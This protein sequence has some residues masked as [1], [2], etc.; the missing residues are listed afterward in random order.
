MNCSFILG[1]H[2]NKALVHVALRIPKSDANGK[3]HKN[4][5]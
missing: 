3:V 2:V 1:K 4:P 5:S